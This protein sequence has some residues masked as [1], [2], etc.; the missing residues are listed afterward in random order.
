[1]IPYIFQNNNAFFTINQKLNQNN[2]TN[3]K[4]IN[5]KFNVNNNFI[6]G[7]HSQKNIKSNPKIQTNPIT[8]KNKSKINSNNLTLDLS[9]E[10]IN[11]IINKYPI[12]FNSENNQPII[13]QND[14]NSSEINNQLPPSINI[15]E[16]SKSYIKDIIDTCKE[17]SLKEK[18]CKINMFNNKKGDDKEKNYIKRLKTEEL[19]KIA[20][21][22]KEQMNKKACNKMEIDSFKTNVIVTEQNKKIDTEN[23]IEIDNYFLKRNKTNRIKIKEEFYSS[24]LKNNNLNI[25]NNL[26]NNNNKMNNNNNINNNT[27]KN[28]LFYIYKNKNNNNQINNIIINDP[29]KNN[30]NK[31]VQIK[32]QRSLNE[33]TKLIS[34]KENSN[35]NRKKNITLNK[36]LISYENRKAY[37]KKTNNNIN[38]EKTGIKRIK[39]SINL[40]LTHN[41]NINIR[42]NNNK[43]NYINSESSKQDIKNIKNFSKINKKENI[44]PNILNFVNKKNISK[45][46]IYN[47]YNEKR[48]MNSHKN[49]KKNN[50]LTNKSQNNLTTDIKY[51]YINLI[52]DDIKNKSKNKENFTTLKKN[53]YTSKKNGNYKEIFQTSPNN[54]NCTKKYYKNITQNK[55]YNILNIKKLKIKANASVRDKIIQKNNKVNDNIN[56][57]KFLQIN[58]NKIN[59]NGFDYRNF[60]IQSN[61]INYLHQNKKEYNYKKLTLNFS[62]IKK[63]DD[64]NKSDNKIKMKK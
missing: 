41:I 24:F 34:P 31:I 61:V 11:N 9:Y 51:N 23:D 40:K 56:N 49:D 36:D 3:K 2:M 20:K 32:K 29:K 4:E 63:S 37:I 12:R 59:N 47:N 8:K 44:S 26:L 6:F 48:K 52:Y 64:I 43:C 14:I 1:M 33:T 10:D 60:S 16:E 25:K 30:I 39:K 5:L 28:H 22:R 17:G 45:I 62:P 27:F 55:S 21:R 38:K 15:D 58:K 57:Y 42:D 46:N 18:N 54:E 35:M 53:I 7:K 19:I 13:N 50:L